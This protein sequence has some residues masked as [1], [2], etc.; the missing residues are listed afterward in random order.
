VAHSAQ[1]FYCKKCRLLVNVRTY[2]QTKDGLYFCR[3]PECGAKNAVVRTGA[4]PSEPG[5]LPVTRLLD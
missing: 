3:C 1:Q 5:I 2:E 4:A